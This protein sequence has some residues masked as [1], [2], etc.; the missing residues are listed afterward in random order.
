MVQA[1]RDMR[2]RHQQTQGLQVLN[3]HVAC[4]GKKNSVTLC[5]DQSMFM[6]LHP[7]DTIPHEQNP[8]FLKLQVTDTYKNTSLL[9]G[10]S[11]NQLYSMCT[12]DVEDKTKTSKHIA[13]TSHP[14]TLN[15][16]RFQ[17]ICILINIEPLKNIQ[18]FRNWS[19]KV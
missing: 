17:S 6:V 11:P 7:F 4:A 1:P 9:A 16:S 8:E 13:R 12:S 3:C 14:C 5:I 15:C 2:S 18:Y 10:G 19:G